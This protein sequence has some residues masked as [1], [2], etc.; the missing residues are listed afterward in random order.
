M[1]RVT[2]IM[3]KSLLTIL[4]SGGLSTPAH[5][6]Y[7]PGVTVDIP[8]AFS[9]DGL[10]IPAGIYQFQLVDRNF[11]M[12]IRNLSSGEERMFNVHPEE[13]RQIS[14]H[15]QVTFQVCRGHSYLTQIHTPGTTLFSATGNRRVK[16]Q[17][18]S[19]AKSDSCSR[20]DA[21]TVAMR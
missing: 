19:I 16:G 7:D 1:K 20:E 8:F 6:Q 13:A 10:E 21:I 4:I 2:S 5:A 12:S 9:V 17:K 18:Q 14:D 11:L 3:V 15:A